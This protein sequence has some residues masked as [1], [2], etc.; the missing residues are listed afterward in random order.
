MYIY[1]YMCIYTHTHV[2]TV[3]MSPPNF[4]QDLFLKNMVF[5][6]TWHIYIYMFYMLV[7]LKSWHLYYSN[8]LNDH[9][10]G[11]DSFERLYISCQWCFTIVQGFPMVLHEYSMF[12]TV[13]YD[14][15]N[16]C[17]HFHDVSMCFNDFP[18]VSFSRNK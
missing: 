17:H 12:S 9:I 8:A 2:P 6:S 3:C 14:F 11:I 4:C 16:D 7:F 10:W 18:P 15:V 5:L 13:L 1:V